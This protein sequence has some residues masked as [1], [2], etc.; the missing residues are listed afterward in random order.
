[1]QGR[2]VLQGMTLPQLVRPPSPSLLRP[3]SRGPPALVELLEAQQ[4]A[5]R[6]LVSEHRSSLQESTTSSMRLL[7]A[8]KR[9]RALS[10]R[11]EWDDETGKAITKALNSDLDGVPV[12]TESQV[13]SL[14]RKLNRAACRM[15]PD[16]RTQAA[17]FQLFQHMDKDKSGLVSYAEVQSMVRHHLKLSKQDLPEQELQATWRWMDEDGSGMIR[18]GEFNKLMRQGWDAFLRANE[19]KPPRWVPVRGTMP[20]DSTWEQL[21]E[22]DHYLSSAQRAAIESTRRLFKTARQLEARKQERLMER[23]ARVES[24]ESLPTRPS[25]VG[26]PSTATRLA[27]LGGSTK[28]K[29]GGG[30]KAMS[31]SAPQLT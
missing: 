8:E 16:T 19:R 11:A 1:M 15:Y 9:A 31:A 20:T 21:K 30:E 17:F 3:P 22:D 18:S 29:R 4:E 13:R 25:T 12:A 27:S 26:S 23:A 24:L 2:H 7:F 10:V 6:Q 5:R 28:T 14:S